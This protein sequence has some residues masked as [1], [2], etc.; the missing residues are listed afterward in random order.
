MKTL[1]Y[2]ISLLNQLKMTYLFL[3]T[4]VDIAINT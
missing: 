1:D 4:K 3:I 2:L